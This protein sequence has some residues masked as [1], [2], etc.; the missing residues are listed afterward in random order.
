VR[1]CRSLRAVPTG[2]VAPGSKCRQDPSVQV[3]TPSDRHTSAADVES[4]GQEV[5]VAGAARGSSLVG[6]TSPA[7]GEAVTSG[8][9]AT[10]EGVQ[11]RLPPEAT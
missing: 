8:G 5:G 2:A 10:G 6:H 11:E 7:A 4:G 3:P 9:E 1:R